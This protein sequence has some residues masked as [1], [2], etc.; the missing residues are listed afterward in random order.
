MPV[1]DADMA[2]VVKAVLALPD[3]TREAIIAR[4]HEW[5]RRVRET[6]AD[7]DASG[8]Y[9]RIAKV[10]ATL[11]QS[12]LAQVWPDGGIPCPLL[13]V[14]PDAA[15][16]TGRCAIYE[17]RPSMCRAHFARGPEACR[18]PRATTVQELPVTQAY[19]KLINGLQMRSAGILA[20]ELR[21]AFRLV[22]VR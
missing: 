1:T 17:S 7:L 12:A 2:L 14:A 3:V 15:P 19:Q 9:D 18:P 10:N 22:V 16:G 8:G 20:V 6:G 4:A 13:D 21:R 11:V 5:H